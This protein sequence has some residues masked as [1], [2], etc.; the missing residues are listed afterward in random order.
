MSKHIRLKYVKPEPETK[1]KAIAVQTVFWTFNEIKWMNILMNVCTVYFRALFLQYLNKLGKD[2]LNVKNIYTSGVWTDCPLKWFYF[3]L[4]LSY[5]YK[6]K[7]L[8]WWTEMTVLLCRVS[9]TLTLYFHCLP[10]RQL[11][12]PEQKRSK[13]ESSADDFCDGILRKQQLIG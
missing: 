3:A 11:R 10:E 4:I 1:S 5:S 13:F 9:H 2:H 8:L 7:L 6:I 12:P